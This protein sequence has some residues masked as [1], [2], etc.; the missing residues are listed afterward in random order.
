MIGMKATR[1]PFIT[2]FA[3]LL[4][5][6]SSTVSPNAALPF[7]LVDEELDVP[8]VH[9]DVNA[10][11]AT[12]TDATNVF[13]ITSSFR[14]QTLRIRAGKWLLRRC[15][16]QLVCLG[17]LLISRMQPRIDSDRSDEDPTPYEVLA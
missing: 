9:A 3:F 4:A 15:A 2:S 11:P 5:A 12:T 6:K 16:S 13:F 1:L 17:G 7:A 8:V 14:G 10:I